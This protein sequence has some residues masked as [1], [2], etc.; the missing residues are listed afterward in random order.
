[1]K[2]RMW[3]AFS[4]ALL[5]AL[6]LAP[7]PSPSGS[8]SAEAL[9]CLAYTLVPDPLP[10]GAM[11][12]LYSVTFQVQ[13]RPNWVIWGTP[14][15]TYRVYS[16]SLPTG[17][18][19]TSAGMLSGT[20]VA[21]GTFGFWIYSEDSHPGQPTT[22]YTCLMS[23]T[24]TISGVNHAP[25]F[26]PGTD[27]TV[28]EDSV[29]YSAP[30]ATNMSPGDG[31][32][33]ALQTL[34]FQLTNDN[35]A[36]FSVQPAI[37]SD[38]TLSFTLKHD[39]NGMATVSVYMKDNGGV[40]NGG[41][42][43]TSTVNFRINVT[44][45]DN[46]LTGPTFTPNTTDMTNDH[47]CTEENCTLREAIEAA[48]KDGVDSIIELPAG[49]RYIVSEVDNTP[50]YAGP[51]GLP[52]ITSPIT[53]NGHG[54][55]I[56]RST[57]L[58]Y[59]RLFHVYGG[60]LTLN[61]IQLEDGTLDPSK[62]E[63]IGGAILNEGHLIVKNSYLAHNAARY[64]GAIYNGGG[65][66]AWIYNS[67]FYANSAQDGAIRSYGSLDLYSNTF[68][69][70][71]GVYES[72]ISLGWTSVTK[73]NF[74]NNLFLSSGSTV[75]LCHLTVPGDI[76][77]V[78]A[79]LATDSS[80][81]GFT[82]TT[83]AAIKAVATLDNNGGL[84][85]NMAIQAGSSAI[86]VGYTAGC[87]NAN[88]NGRDQRGKTRFADGNGDGVA[89]CD[90]GAYEYSALQL[91]PP[92]QPE[93]DPPVTTILLT[94][95]GPDGSN[96]WYRS[97]VAVMPEASDTSPVIKLRCVLDPA[98]PP[99]TFDDLPEELCPF[100]G[101]AQV[102][103]DGLH[104]FYA[105]AMDIWGNK[106]EVASGSFQIDATP[107]AITCPAAGPFLLCSGD[108]MVGPAGV[109]A[110]V[111]GLDEAASTLSGI[112]V[113]E[114]VGPK[115]LTF[116]AVDLAG[117]SASL[118]CTYKVIY[119][120]AGYYL[121]VQPA[122]ALNPIKAGQAVP[123]KFSLAGDQGLEVIAAGYPASQPVACDTLAPAGPLEA[124]ETAGKSGLS[125]AAGNGRYNYVWKTD[126]AW[127]GTCRALTLRLVDG[128]EH[129][130]YFWFK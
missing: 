30:W 123:L 76:I 126:K 95:A 91:P 50:Y 21:P 4:A 73:Y 24:I 17:L 92:A 127:G 42:D 115:T 62:E 22:P 119:D 66:A 100:L 63:S 10:N 98:S 6:V 35:N 34:S 77:K 25:A 80:C 74:Y 67:T 56:T 12:T 48:N 46:V 39:A 64:A 125:Y 97:P 65:P 14:P 26:T 104:A 120:F 55:L 41:V 8:A 106:S 90:V 82:V 84:T 83:Y 102:S 3:L 124:T 40:A 7:A 109:D 78:G 43:S 116:T 47:S 61:E 1:M 53:I 122:P 117:N 5:L 58:P 81:T 94:P 71:T 31:T 85:K 103:A 2:T 75:P 57:A 54:A 27:V 52:Q 23:Y 28:D 18:T 44:P 68:F 9:D 51:N 60:D 49:A 128:T 11:G 129:L 130:T 111:S 20:P 113:T 112:V 105:A 72:A 38:G 33:E 13:R 16:G 32:E 15:Y 19:L 108:Q 101:G 37:A 110:S 89:Q 86:D 79:N 36:L 87:Q 29:P 121:P 88:I 69:D 118:D 93:T 114:S 99:A 70:N 59:A 45:V 107:P 96:G